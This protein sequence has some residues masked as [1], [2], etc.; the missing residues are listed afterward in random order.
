MHSH[1]FKYLVPTVDGRIVTFF[2]LLFYDRQT[3]HR[4]NKDITN[5]NV[6]NYCNC[7]TKKKKNTNTWILSMLQKQLSW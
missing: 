3:V 7:H 2:L 4:E 5:N 1:L 6:T